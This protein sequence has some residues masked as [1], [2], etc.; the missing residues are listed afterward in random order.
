MCWRSAIKEISRRGFIQ[1]TGAGLLT[2]MPSLRGNQARAEEPASH[3]DD[4]CFMPATML[5][6]AIR[7]KRV[8][9]VEV[10]NSVY[11]RIHEVNPKING[12]SRKPRCV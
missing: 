10:I 1:T 12:A 3:G 7:Q 2:M 4:L 11:A 9:T 8:S 6:A 5:A